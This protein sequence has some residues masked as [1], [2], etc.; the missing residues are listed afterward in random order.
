[1]EGCFK[2][3]RQPLNGRTY[4]ACP[5]RFLL[6]TSGRFQGTVR[7][8]GEFFAYGRLSSSAKYFLLF[9]LIASRSR[10]ADLCVLVAIL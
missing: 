6:I 8:M 7:T 4:G 9:C 5:A 1:M 10:F 3:V 2:V